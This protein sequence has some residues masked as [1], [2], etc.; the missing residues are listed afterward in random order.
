MKFL[1]SLSF[2]LE[3]RYVVS[4]TGVVALAA[5]QRAAVVWGC[6]L[7]P[8]LIKHAQENARIAQLEA[9]FVEPDV[10]NLPYEN[11]AFNV[12]LSQYGHIFAPRPDVALGEMLR[13]LKPFGTIAFSTLPPEHLCGRL[14]DA[15]SKY[16]PPQ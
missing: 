4:G 5:A 16:F 8:V 13:V 2:P 15:I 12:V 1:L 7:A 14:F 11:E 6:D 10:E 3:L 9:Q